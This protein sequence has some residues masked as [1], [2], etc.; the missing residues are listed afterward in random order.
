ILLSNQLAD[1]LGFGSDLKDTLLRAARLCKNDL[2]SEMVR[3]YPQLHGIMGAIYAR[4]FGESEEVC[5]AIAWY[6]YP[7]SPGDPLPENNCAVVLGIL[8]RL[9]F[10]C[11]FIAAG[12]DVSGSEDPYGLKRAT[13]GLFSL[14]LKLEREL[15][16]ACVVKNVLQTYGM[17]EK[18]FLA[19]EKTLREFLTQRFEAYLDAEGF[20][21]GLRA[22][23]ISVE[24]LNFVRIRKK[25]ESLRDFIKNTKDADVVLIPVIRITNILKQASEKGIVIPEFN[26]NLLMVNAEIALAELYAKFSKISEEALEKGNYSVFLTIVSELKKPVDEFFN[27]VLVMC[28]EE[29]LRDNRLALLKKFNDIFSKFADFSFIRE[30]DLKNVGKD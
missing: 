8:D 22:S 17:P 24:N 25:L 26:T 6:K 13:S 29:K 11:G 3:E 15:D 5:N 4:H 23:V 12:A 30:E 21:K 10:I 18:D 20:P 2:A 9:D 7:V 16:Y 1:M 14:V 19:S 28:P 27:N